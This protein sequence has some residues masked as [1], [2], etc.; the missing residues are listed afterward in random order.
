MPA[1]LAPSR[2]NTAGTDDR[3]K[4]DEAILGDCDT[5]QPCST[6]L[7]RA[8]VHD[9]EDEPYDETEIAL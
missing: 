8:E 9:A 1:F 7:R 2:G 6:A 4:I 5:M 3:G